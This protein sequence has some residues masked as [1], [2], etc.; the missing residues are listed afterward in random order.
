MRQPPGYESP[1]ELPQCLVLAKYVNESGVALCGVATPI[2]ETCLN[3][4]DR[5]SE[6]ATMEWVLGLREPARVA[7]IGF[8]V[9]AFAL[10]QYRRLWPGPRPW[11]AGH[12]RDDR[13]V[14]EDFGHCDELRERKMAA[15][16]WPGIIARHAKKQIISHAR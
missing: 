1:A 16:V 9:V 11:F 15:A 2:T 10:G 7:R 6:V 13:W 5:H 3:V 14:P 8:G 4:F 12:W